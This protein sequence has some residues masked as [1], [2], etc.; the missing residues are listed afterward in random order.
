M[1]TNINSRITKSI[2]LNLPMELYHQ[3]CL[4]PLY[5]KCSH[6]AEFIRAILREYLDNSN[7]ATASCQEKISQQA[8][9]NDMQ[10]VVA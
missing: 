5:K 2:G 3:L 1:S 9:Q 8:I 10:K 7:K 4:L 6:D